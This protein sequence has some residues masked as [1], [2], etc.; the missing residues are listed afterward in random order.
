MLTSPGA[1]S[2]CSA[3]ISPVNGSRIRIC[4]PSTAISTVVPMSCEGTEYRADPNRTHDSLS[5]LRLAG[6][7]PVSHR[8]DGSGPSSSRSVPRR[9]AG[10]AKISL[11]CA[12]LASAHQAAACLFAAARSATSRLA[13]TMRSRLA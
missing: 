6:R 3:A 8:S 9:W 4:V 11:C 10:T 1:T 2:A 5:T 12:A 13:G 7:A